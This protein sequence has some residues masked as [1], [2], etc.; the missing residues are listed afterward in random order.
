LEDGGESGPAS[1]L[2]N[3]VAPRP[4]IDNPNGTIIYLDA[5]SSTS[6]TAASG[7]PAQLSPVSTSSVKEMIALYAQLLVLLRQEVALLEAL[8]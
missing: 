4:Q 7:T 6:T 1:A 3:Y 8:K 2:P 5:T